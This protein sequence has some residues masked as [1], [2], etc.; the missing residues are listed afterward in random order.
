MIYEQSTKE[1]QERNSHKRVVVA[2]SGGVDSSVAAAILVNQGYDVIGL[3]MRLWSEPNTFGAQQ[4]N[5]CCTP[6]QMADARRVADQL[7]IPFYVIAVEKE[8]PYETG[9]WQVTD[10][11]L[12]LAAQ[13][14]EIAIDELLVCEERDEWPSRFEELRYLEVL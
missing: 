2:M 4:A 10:A 11:C 3:M 8:P 7:Q 12:D 9:V 6:D 14:N 13:K 5:R 1:Q